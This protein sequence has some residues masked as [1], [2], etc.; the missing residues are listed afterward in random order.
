MVATRISVAEFEATCGDDRV[1]LIDGEIVPMAPASMEPAR[2]TMRLGALLTVHVMQH[3]LGDAF[4]A[5]AGF[6]M[7]ED[8][9]TVVAPDVAFVRAGRLP[10]G[11]ARWHF[12]RLVPD[13][14]AEVISPSDRPRDIAAKT[15]L[16]QEAG[17]PLLWIMDPRAQAVTVLALGQE[18]VT[19]GIGDELDGGEVLP[20]FRVA[21]A[22]IF[23]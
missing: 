17:V 16:Y 9:Q 20:E 13:L 4:S 22:E 12:A 15:A 18:P 10:Q 21:I 11:E 7:F 6:V 19:L 23:A 1:E 8:R 14:V 2:V 3:Q 5:E